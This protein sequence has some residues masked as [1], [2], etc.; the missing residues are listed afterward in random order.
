MAI[1]PSAGQLQ[2][3]KLAQSA[4]ASA[5][6]A[7]TAFSCWSRSAVEQKGD[8]VIK[9][10]TEIIVDGYP[11]GQTDFLTR[12]NEADFLTQDRF[13]THIIQP[14]IAVLETT[15]QTAVLT[16]TGHGDRVDTEGL[17]REQRRQLEFEASDAR[18]TSAKAGV[19][20][21]INNQT[22]FFIPDDLN[23]L[24]QLFVAD[25]PA[26]AAVLRESGESLTEEQRLRNRRVQFRLIRFQPS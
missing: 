13:D 18:A 17:S 23:D 4:T 10:I 12:L 5:R 14:M 8:Q 25:R 3:A 26:G 16:I 24:E 15:D 22:P 11:S 20:E 19:R 2:G 7:W 6:N 9:T 1:Y 21:L